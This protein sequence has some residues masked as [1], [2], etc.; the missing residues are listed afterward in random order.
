MTP[1]AECSPV[2]EGEKI[3]GRSQRRSSGDGAGEEREGQKWISAKGK[4]KRKREEKDE[5]VSGTG[6]TVPSGPFVSFNTGK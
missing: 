4:R 1:E 3:G 6:S 5:L 2:R